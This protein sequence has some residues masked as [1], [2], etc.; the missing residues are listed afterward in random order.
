MNQL[1]ACAEVNHLPWNVSVEFYQAAT[2]RAIAIM[3]RVEI[4]RECQVHVN[5]FGPQLHGLHEHN[6]SNTQKWSKNLCLSGDGVCQPSNG[7]VHRLTSSNM[8]L[9]RQ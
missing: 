6:T 4:P 8:F 3:T 2:W 1:V 7:L 5:V 9:C